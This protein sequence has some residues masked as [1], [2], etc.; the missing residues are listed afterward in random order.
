MKHPADLDGLI[1][2]GRRSRRPLPS[3]VRRLRIA[4]SIPET[5]TGH[6]S[7]RAFLLGQTLADIGRI[8]SPF[9][10]NAGRIEEKQPVA[11]FV[12][13]VYQAL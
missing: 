11:G 5:F 3:N 9:E 7:G 13:L 6:A 2:I 4:G 1:Y 10:R 8:Q 12:G